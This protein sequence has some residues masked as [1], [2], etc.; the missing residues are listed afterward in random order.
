VKSHIVIACRACG[1]GGSVAS[2]ALRHARELS[3]DFHV[4]LLSDSFPEQDFNK[5]NLKKVSPRKFD[6]LRRFCHVP[7]EYAFA[8]AVLKRLESLHMN[9]GVDLVMCHSHA[10]AAISALKL[11]QKYKIP[12]ALITHGDIFDRPADA[13][14]Y[15]WLLTAFYRGVTPPAYE[16]ADLIIAIS[17]YMASCAM[18]NGAKPDVVKVVP[19]GIDPSDIGVNLQ[20]PFS[21]RKL[22]RMER[23]FCLLYVGRLT[24]LKG[25][26]MLI[27]ACDILKKR[28]VHFLLNVIGDGPLRADLQNFIK[29]KGLSKHIIY[30][31]K[32]ERKK[33]GDYYRS[34]DLVC[35]P[36]LSEAQGVVVLESLIVGTPV[37]A[38]NV[39]GIT[40]ML[41][42][43][44]NGIIVPPRDPGAIAD[45]IE[46]LSNKPNKLN[47]LS[48]K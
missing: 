37:V 38:S 5:I 3:N 8:M 7:N 35:V 21:M 47:A 32:V 45:A 23:A 16:G 22:S 42:P 12:Y 10:L 41:K 34:A 1:D 28:G 20:T 14:E 29:S 36:S 15:H 4:T 24:T 19:N 27:M 40:S 2:V 30:F 44:V 48:E 17:P 33:L 25:F 43:G 11:K 9:K 31:G 13:I 46:D 6:Y 39:G 18:R 26:D